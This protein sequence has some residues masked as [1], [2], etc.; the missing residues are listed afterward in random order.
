ML[1]G[2]FGV[3]VKFAEFFGHA[4]DSKF[5]VVELSAVSLQLSAFRDQ[6]QLGVVTMYYEPF[7]ACPKSP[8]R[9]LV[10]LKLTAQSS[11]LKAEG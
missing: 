1:A 6:R 11:L 10:A 8:G 7:P 9:I 4:A 3:L 5:G 2:L